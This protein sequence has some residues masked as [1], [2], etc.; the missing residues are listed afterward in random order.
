MLTTLNPKEGKNARIHDLSEFIKPLLIK[1]INIIINPEWYDLNFLYYF[2][3]EWFTITKHLRDTLI[4]NSIFPVNPQNKIP[5]I[6]K[7]WPVL[8]IDHS[9]KN[10]SLKQFLNQQFQYKETRNFNGELKL[11]LYD[12]KIK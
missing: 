10:D 1:P 7:L 3:P 6:N 2:N 4:L 12:V 5:F 11:I 9:N 8:L